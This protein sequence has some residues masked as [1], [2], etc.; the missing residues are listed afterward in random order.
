M[1][2]NRSGC[3]GGMSALLLT[4]VSRIRLDCLTV[5]VMRDSG[6]F[7]FNSFDDDMTPRLVFFIRDTGA[8]LPC[9]GGTSPAVDA[10]D[11]GET[12]ADIEDNES[13]LVSL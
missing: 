6:V 4:I 2:L 1:S 3:G 10:D 11:V 8:P 13:R 9:V 7:V 12:M 5:L